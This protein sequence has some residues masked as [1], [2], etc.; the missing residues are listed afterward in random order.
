[1]KNIISV[2][3]LSLL[4]LVFVA[5]D[6]NKEPENPEPP[7]ADTTEVVVPTDTIVEVVDTVVTDTVPAA[8]P[9]TFTMSL[10]GDNLTIIPSD[11]E[12]TYIYMVFSYVD[13]NTNDLLL[14]AYS[15]HA[16]EV[17]T[18]IHEHNLGGVSRTLT[19]IAVG[20]NPE[21]NEVTSEFCHIEFEY[22]NDNVI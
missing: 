16:A 19:L 3:A 1:M 14:L 12:A 17:V 20:I 6:H 4:T 5:C 7:I 10:D 13:E 8:E 18:G 21:T 11:L 2:I 9:L 22:V 15:K